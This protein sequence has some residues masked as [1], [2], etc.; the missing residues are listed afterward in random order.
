MLKRLLVWLV[1]LSTFATGVL[2]GLSLAL[3]SRSFKEKLEEGLGP[4]ERQ[5]VADLSSDALASERRFGRSRACWI[6]HNWI[7]RRPET[8]LLQIVIGDTR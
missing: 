6:Q 5:P 1:L 8:W 7:S 2:V 4:F 3:P